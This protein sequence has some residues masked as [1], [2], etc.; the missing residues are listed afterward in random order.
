MDSYKISEILPVAAQNELTGFD[1]LTQKLLHNRGI[2]TRQAAEK[3]LNPD[4][5]RDCYDPFLILN[6]DRAVERI[7]RAIDGSE[8]IV[9]YGDYDCDGIPG[10][11]ILHDF[12]KKSAIKIFQIIFHIGTRKDTD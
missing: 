9:V 4:Y 12:L 6:M 2:A 7:L 3:F 11:V 5:E 1:P 10:S 8:K